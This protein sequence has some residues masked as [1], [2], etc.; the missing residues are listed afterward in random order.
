MD[1]YNYEEAMVNDIKEW[2]LMNGVLSQAKSEE[3]TRDELYD[4]LFDELWAHDCITGNGCYYY[5]PE[6]KCE[7]YVAHNLSLYFEAAAEFDDW[8]RSGPQWVYSNPAQH[9][10]TTIRC[11]LLGTSIDRAIEEL[12]YEVN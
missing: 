7:E 11:Y 12:N 8:P 10:D 2:I 3:W 1:K 6:E 5:A 9:M 4:W